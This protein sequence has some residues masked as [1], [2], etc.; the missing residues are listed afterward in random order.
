MP[1]MYV[2]VMRMLHIHC[3]V[4][5]LICVLY[6][7]MYVYIYIYNIMCVCVYYLLGLHLWGYLCVL[8]MYIQ[9]EGS[10]FKMHVSD[11]RKKILA[12]A[13]QHARDV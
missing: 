4:E 12:H 11:E 7:Y 6:I 1:E 2:Y 13:N 9:T 3:Y 8:S 5:E 10:L